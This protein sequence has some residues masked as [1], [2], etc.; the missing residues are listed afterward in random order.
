MKVVLIKKTNRIKNVV[1]ISQVPSF[2][3][4]EQKK[5]EK[6]QINQS[7]GPRTKNSGVSP[8]TMGAKYESRKP[9]PGI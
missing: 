5:P 2:D 9:V 1:L 7:T 4:S 6:K 3:L 8:Q